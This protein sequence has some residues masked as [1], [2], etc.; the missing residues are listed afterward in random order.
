MPPSG[1]VTLPK[2]VRVEHFVDS[3]FKTG[4]ANDFS[5]CATWGVDTDFNA[6]RLGLWRKRVEFPELVENLTRIYRTSR[7]RG[8]VVIED[9]ASGQSAIQVLKRSGVPV[10]PWPGKGAPR[11]GSASKESRA[12]AVTYLVEAGKVFVPGRKG[13]DGEVQPATREDEEFIEEHAAFPSGTH[14]DM[15]DTTTMALLRLV[16]WRKKPPEWGATP[17]GLGDEPR[18]RTGRF[19][20]FGGE[21]A[22]LER[23]GRDLIDRKGVARLRST[24][25]LGGLEWD[26]LET[27]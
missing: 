21:Q 14:D 20:P 18:R 5:V 2:L 8:P 25:D 4:I 15:V 26:D 19:D 1:L 9:K 7:W 17:Y 27:T 22:E 6:Y 3:A 11:V 24:K 12:D 13:P 10:V 23:I 16:V